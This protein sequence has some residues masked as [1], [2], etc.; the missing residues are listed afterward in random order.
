MKLFRE[1]ECGNATIFFAISASVFFG[2][3]ALAV[4]IGFI[5]AAKNQM[6]IAVD[7]AALASASGLT[8]SQ[9]E[10]RQRALDNSTRNTILGQALNLSSAEI[11]FPRTRA[12][13]IA[14]T[15]QVNL[16]F[17]RLFGLNSVS[18][19]ASA[20]AEL[21]N[22]DI[23]LILDRSG[24]M[25]DDT[26]DPDVPQPLTDTQAAAKY[27]VNKIEN[28]NFTLDRMGLV[29]YSTWATR[30][31]DLDRDFQDIRDA[32][33]DTDADGWTNIGM[34][35]D[36]ANTHLLNEARWRTFKIEI[37][38][39]DG[40]A[41]RPY[42]SYYGRWYALYKAQQA[43]DDDIKIFT[44]SLGDDTDWN[45]MEEIAS[46]TGGK[47]FYAPTAQELDDIFDEVAEWIPCVLVQ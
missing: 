6:Q 23:I 46:K 9:S 24:S 18:V 43:A 25:D 27:F 38:L 29:T 33:D 21:G 15:R 47:H 12:V 3:A 5:S 4:D 16:F 30:D 19:S 44:I 22:R 42:N 11:T 13:R 8:A 20:E 17:A 2:F 28:S 40:M 10:S 39:S 26:V 31:E 37:L 41:N 7:A 34:A 45:L 1:K 35:I 14:A 32:I 36:L